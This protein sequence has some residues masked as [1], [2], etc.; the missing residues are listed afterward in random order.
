MA[1]R[2]DRWRTA[3]EVRAHRKAQLKYEASPKEVKK[4]ENR[5]QARRVLER[6]GRVSK[7][8]GKDVAHKDGSALNN[9]PQNWAIQTRHKNRSYKRT[10]GAHKLDP[11]S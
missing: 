5:N 8:D 2:Y 6:E 3:A 4:R 10:K 9:S 7:G 11:R 1:A